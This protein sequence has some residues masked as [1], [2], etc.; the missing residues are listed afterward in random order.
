VLAKL[1][2]RLGLTTGF[3][4]RTAF[5]RYVVAPLC[6]PTAD[7][8]GFELTLDRADSL[9]LG[10]NGD[11]EPDVRGVIARCLGAGDTFVDVG[12]N[13]GWFSL[14]ASR[15]VG[16]EG[17][18]VALEPEA[19]NF[20]LL[21][22]NAARNECY[23]VLPFRLAASDSHGTAMLE[24]D[25]ENAGGHRLAETGQPVATA[26]LADLVRSL[27]RTPALVKID[28]E[29]AEVR[30]LDGMGSLLAETA[31][32]L[33][34]APA[35]LSGNGSDPAAL[36]DRLREQTEVVHVMGSDWLPADSVDAVMGRLA[37]YPYAQLLCRPRT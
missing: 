33:E 6:G 30:V 4:R 8:Q 13:I 35:A 37:G 10:L 29:G 7:V 28:V 23:N 18:V 9:G 19:G 32:L 12:A 31:V 15:Q 20:E 2:H 26:R 11:Y 25:R 3:R 1:G 17:C 5:S 21:A 27:G 22:H 16:P 36:L 24:L 14:L 34:F